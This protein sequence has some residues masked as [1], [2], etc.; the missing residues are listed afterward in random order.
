MPPD[1]FVFT[2]NWPEHCCW[3]HS[4]RDS[5]SLPTLLHRHLLVS[6]KT[7]CQIWHPYQTAWQT[8]LLISEH[9]VLIQPAPQ[10]LPWLIS[11]RALLTTQLQLRSY[12]WGTGNSSPEHYIIFYSN[13]QKARVKANIILYLK[14]VFVYYSFSTAFICNTLCIP[15][16]L[17]P[18]FLFLIA[19]L[20]AGRIATRCI[21]WARSFPLWE[22]DNVIKNNRS[23][24]PQS[25]LN[26]PKGSICE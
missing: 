14:Y 9:S 12:T 11:E 3:Q 21:C 4:V 16:P 26:V 20:P 10:L 8:S 23:E 7:G 2:D 5:G 6:P 25:L 22:Q 17:H 1:V 15:S 13:L 18:P 24:Q 19:M